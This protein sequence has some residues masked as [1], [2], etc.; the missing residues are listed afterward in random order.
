M[1]S[2]ILI[3]VDGIVVTWT[4]LYNPSRVDFELPPRGILPFV[5]D[6]GQVDDII[7]E[8]AAPSTVQEGVSFSVTI[9]AE[10]GGS[11]APN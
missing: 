11:A 9:R 6:D 3:S 10:A 8:T 4:G 2:Y 5:I 7:V 1:S